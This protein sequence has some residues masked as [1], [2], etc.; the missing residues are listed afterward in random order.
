MREEAMIDA[1][2]GKLVT[3]HPP[4]TCTVELTESV[5]FSFTHE[6]DGAC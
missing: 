1:Q 6:R 4:E 3:R 5:P 2:R